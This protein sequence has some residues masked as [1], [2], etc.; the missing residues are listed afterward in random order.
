MS[1]D[2]TASQKTWMIETLAEL[3]RVIQREFD[4]EELEYLRYLFANHPSIKQLMHQAMHYHSNRD[5]KG[6][7][8]HMK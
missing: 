4:G 5:R 8:A 6:H 2:P 7:E 3:T 1:K